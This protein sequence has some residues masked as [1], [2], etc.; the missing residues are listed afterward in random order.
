MTM[1][2]EMAKAIAAACLSLASA[3]AFLDAAAAQGLND[4]LRDARKNQSEFS[5]KAE[6][7]AVEG[8]GSARALSVGKDDSEQTIRNFNRELELKNLRAL[9]KDLQ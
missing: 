2:T 7:P 3:F 9:R 5:A 8:A 1:V 4:L 6:L